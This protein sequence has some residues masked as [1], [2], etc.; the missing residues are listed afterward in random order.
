MALPA[1]APAQSVSVEEGGPSDA[2]PRLEEL[3]ALGYEAIQRRV[4][5][6]VR[7][8]LTRRALLYEAPTLASKPRGFL[9]EGDTVLV[10]TRVRDMYGVATE[11]QGHVGYLFASVTNRAPN[12][13]P[14]RLDRTVTYRSRLAARSGQQA[15]EVDRRT[16]QDPVRFRYVHW[17]DPAA[18]TLFSILIPGGGHLYAGE[19]R[20]GFFLLGSSFLATSVGAVLT[21][22]SVEADCSAGFYEPC[23]EATNYTPL[24]VGATYAALAYL[25]GVVDAANAAE[26]HNDKMRALSAGLTYSRA[27][28]GGV[29]LSVR[30]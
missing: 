17:K 24:V 26:R 10:H 9:P 2:P 7:V 8:V 6:A 21:L 1:R 13:L 4:P 3:E 23:E 29:V 11:E 28:G 15:A 12:E 18:A 20:T 27:G 5:E 22:D 14:A 16:T 30:F 25:Y 19:A